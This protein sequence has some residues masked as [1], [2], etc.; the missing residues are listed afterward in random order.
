[1]K[2]VSTFLCD[3][4]STYDRK[5]LVM[6]LI[7]FVFLGMLEVIREELPDTPLYYTIAGLCTRLHCQAIPLIDIR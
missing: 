5:I 1:M 6:Y 3:F 2:V 7:D 4:Y